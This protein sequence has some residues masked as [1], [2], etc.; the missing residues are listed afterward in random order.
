MRSVWVLRWRR[1]RFRFVPLGPQEGEG[2][3]GRREIELEDHAPSALDGLE[4]R[5]RETEV[6]AAIDALPW[7]YRELILLRHYGELAYDGGYGNAFSLS[8]AAVKTALKASSV[9][10]VDKDVKKLFSAATKGGDY[11]VGIIC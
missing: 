7:E 6:R 9:M 10:V 1:R 4:A 11:I 5:E 2:S 8:P 3:E